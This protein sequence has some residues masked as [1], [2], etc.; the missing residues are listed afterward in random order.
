[1]KKTS[2]C[3]AAVFAV[4][5]GFFVASCSGG[6]DSP[7]LTLYMQPSGGSSDSGGGTQ[8]PTPT[9][10]AEYNVTYVITNGSDDMTGE[11]RSSG[12]YTAQSEL[13][14]PQKEGFQFKGWN[15]DQEQTQA[16]ASFAG[17]TGDV[18]LYGHWAGTLYTVVIEGIDG[19]SRS[20]PMLPGYKDE[21]EW[22]FTDTFSCQYTIRAQI[23][24]SIE[25]TTIEL[26]IYSKRYYSFKGLY[27]DSEFNGTAVTQIDK[28]SAAPGSTLTLYVKWTEKVY[29]F[30]YDLLFDSGVTNP[31]ENFEITISSEPKILKEP[32]HIDSNYKFGGWYVQDSCLSQEFSGWYRGCVT[33]VKIE[34]KR[35]TQYNKGTS[36]NFSFSR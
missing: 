25:D 11:S 2:L 35:Y 23:E 22:R 20:S 36:K 3:F 29:K 1:M 12:K 28:S 17:L 7:N 13:T 21:W 32:T 31:N 34:R 24:F 8:T 18:T 5:F 6:A 14:I 27:L 19:G 26:P 4:L 9:P 16:V 33:E 10:P 15:S 30:N